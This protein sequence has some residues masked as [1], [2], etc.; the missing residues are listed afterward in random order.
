MSLSLAVSEG[1]SAQWSASGGVSAGVVSGGVGFNVT[2]TYTV[3]ATGTVQVPAGKTYKLTAYP[4]YDVYVYDVYY[5]P[6]VGGEYYVGS[7]YAM[8]PISVCYAWYAI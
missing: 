6:A 4:M 8:K 2:A 3:T 1:V 7:G 5:N